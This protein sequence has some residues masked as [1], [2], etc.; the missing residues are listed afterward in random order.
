M[1]K[2]KSGRLEDLANAVA[3][4]VTLADHDALVAAD[5]VE[6][7]HVDTGM[8]RKQIREAFGFFSIKN[9]CELHVLAGKKIP[10]NPDEWRDLAEEAR[11]QME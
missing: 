4:N 6:P 11:K 3:R 1:K 9:I 10:M 8:T 7:I 5:T 2:R